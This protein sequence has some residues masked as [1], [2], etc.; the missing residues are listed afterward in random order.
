MKRLLAFWLFAL[1]LAQSA[2]AQNYQFQNSMSREV[3]DNYLDRAITMQGQSEVEG[4]LMLT[5]TARQQN[6]VMLNDI[7]A[8]FVGRIGGWW[9]NGYGQ[10]QH[11]ALFAKVQQNTY[12]IHA[13]DPQVIC[14]AAVFEFVNGVVN[15]VAIPSRVFQEFGLPITN[16]TFNYD[17][18][19]YPAPA[20]RYKIYNGNDMREDQR[21]WMPDITQ[22]ETQ[23]WFYYMATRYISA[24]CEA[25]HFGQTEVMSRRDVGNKQWWSLLQRVRTYAKNNARRGLVL[26]DAHVAGIGTYYEP[27]LSLTIDQWQT[28]VP[29][30]DWQK[31]LLW[32]FHSQPTN[33]TESNGCT[34]S[35][36]PVTLN[37]QSNTGLYLRSLGGRNPQGWLCRRNPFLVELDN[38]VEPGVPGCNHDRPWT[39][40]GWDEISWFALQD[41]SYRNRILS[42]T[43]SKVKCIDP[44]GHF[45]MPGMRGVTPFNNQ[46]TFLYRANTGIHNQQVTI[47]NIWSGYY[48]TGQNWVKHNFSDEQ[49][50]YS[51]GPGIASSNLIFVGNNRMY[52]IGTDSHVH[53][54]I[55]YNG[56]WLTASP[57]YAAGNVSGQMTASSAPGSL[58]ANPSGT[59]LYYRGTDGFVYQFQIVDDWTYAY[60]N[61]PSNSGVRAVGSLVCPADGR[62]YY[63]AAESSNG[64]A[65]RVHGFIKYGSSW[66]TVSPSSASSNATSQ[67]QMQAAG[68]LIA[69]PSGTAL[70][71][72]GTDGF[73]YQFQIDS[74]WSYFY[75][76]M[77]SNSGVRAVGSLVCPTDGRIY[78]IAAESSN[79]N[80]QRVHGFHKVW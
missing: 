49:V 68:D 52:Y 79:G 16:R 36:Q 15:T 9:D 74:D 80:A 54:Y 2:L 20:S 14:Q 77:P 76:S 50:I 47:K 4:T 1:S 28:Y 37:P 69:N 17:V 67:S 59:A 19:L 40:W 12:D 51:P 32:D 8:K 24:G 75:S 11:D 26:C 48:A 33:Y 43:Y 3:L 22:L 65:Q 62:I 53:A 72:R 23:M 6:V 10:G 63:I 73:I 35:R 39:L 7:G 57:S 25:I 34:A 41:E 64:N 44:N 70:Y 56:T 27:N 61:M 18:M 5:E 58:V 71:Y 42:Y 21:A 46:P 29:T 45:E 13:N 60:S 38:G 66:L 30:Q 78:Y 55:K 31:Q